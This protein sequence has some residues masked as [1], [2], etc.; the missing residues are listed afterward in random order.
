MAR[1]T[2]DNAP[3]VEAR[4]GFPTPDSSAITGTAAQAFYK[5]GGT[6]IPKKEEGGET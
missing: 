6:V 5:K 4:Q 3:F 2:S 1:A